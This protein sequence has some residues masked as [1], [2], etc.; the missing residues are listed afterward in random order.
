MPVKF[1]MGLG[2]RPHQGH[3]TWVSKEDSAELDA[4]LINKL[5]VQLSKCDYAPQRPLPSWSME[6]FCGYPGTYNGNVIGSTQGDWRPFAARVR[7]HGQ[8]LWKNTLVIEPMKQK[9]WKNVRVP[10]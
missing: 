2:C 1:R 4:N 6:L 7:W 8:P 10:A 9:V 3:Y 5:P